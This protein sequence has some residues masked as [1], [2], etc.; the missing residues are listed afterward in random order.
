MA[1]LEETV[2]KIDPTLAAV[3]ERVIR[4][5][6]AIL[7]SRSKGAASRCAVKLDRNLEESQIDRHR[8]SRSKN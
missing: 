4:N 7:K 5:R 3:L 6:E 2:P 1:V 8:P